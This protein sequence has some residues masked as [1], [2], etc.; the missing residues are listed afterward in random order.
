MVVHPRDV[1]DENFGRYGSIARLPSENPLA[2]DE[3]FS[4]WSDVAN[5]HIE[6]DTEIGYCTVYRRDGQVIPWVEKHDRSPELLIPID[7]A[8]HLPVL[9][10]DDSEE[11]VAVFEASPGEAVVIGAGIWHG[12]CQPA[13]SDEATYFVIFRRGTPQED[14]TKRDLTDV[15]IAQ[16][17]AAD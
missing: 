7:H 17:T 8:F 13:A 16:S 11:D 3:T 9:R 15:S 2:A 5:F 6:G 10:P 14:V 12:A 1:T 4:F